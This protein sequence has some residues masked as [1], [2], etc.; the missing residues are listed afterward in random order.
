MFGMNGGRLKRKESK[1]TAENR[2]PPTAVPLQ[3]PAVCF[4]HFHW[5]ATPLRIQ[6]V[7]MRIKIASRLD[8]QYAVLVSEYLLQN[9]TL[10]NLRVVRSNVE[11]EVF[12]MR[13]II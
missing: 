7:K 8:V 4:L 3:F 12:H 9:G 6:S 2:Y 5:T 13:I 1:F 11:M 10:G